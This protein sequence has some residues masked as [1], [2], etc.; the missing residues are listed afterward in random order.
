MSEL[1]RMIEVLGQA[2]DGQLAG[3]IADW[4]KQW[5][6]DKTHEEDVSFIRDIR[7]IAVNNGGASSLVMAVFE[8]MLSGVDEEVTEAAELRRESL[9]ERFRKRVT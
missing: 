9:P 8:E 3:G 2:P 6:A 1:S 4:C 7:D 5:P